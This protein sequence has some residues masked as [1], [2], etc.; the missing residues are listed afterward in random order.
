MRTRTSS[1]TIRW[2]LVRVVFRRGLGQSFHDLASHAP[3]PLASLDERKALTAIQHCC[4]SA[5][6]LTS[7]DA[8]EDWQTCHSIFRTIN[9]HSTPP[10]AL[11]GRIL[12]A[13]EVHRLRLDTD[14]STVSAENTERFDQFTTR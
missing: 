14:A 10:D 3:I 2:D 8:Q 11:V 4:R 5:I 1:K 7:F 6:S 9:F 13:R 12:T